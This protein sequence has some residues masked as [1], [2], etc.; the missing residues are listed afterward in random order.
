MLHSSLRNV[1]IAAWLF[2]HAVVQAGNGPTVLAIDSANSQVLIQVG[3]AGMFGFAGHAHEVTA[4]DV[5]GRVRFDPADLQHASV[6]LEFAAA[7]LRVTGKDEPPAD[8]ADVQKVM[9]G[10]RVLDVT[11]FPTIVFLS[12]RVS[13][14]ARTAGT[15]DIVIEGD[16]TLHATT[17]PMTI[18]ASVTLD[19]G[20]RITAR[21]SFVLKQTD[22]GM[23]P[24]TAVGGTIRV[25]DELDIQFVL[26]TR[27]SDET[28]TAQ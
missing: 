16:M 9:L 13:V 11:R 21:G 26:R 23:V 6:S 19:A 10:E 18:R 8:V 5:R 14:T 15:A 24:V 17:R 3:K 20:G 7:A 12:R 2:T 28:R 4:T 25:K 27:P 22:F 1:S